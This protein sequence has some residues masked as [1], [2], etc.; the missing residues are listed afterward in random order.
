LLTKVLYVSC[1]L[2]KNTDA[3]AFA[4]GGIVEFVRGNIEG[5]VTDN[6]GC[7]H[8]G[9]TRVYFQVNLLATDGQVRDKRTCPQLELLRVSYVQP[10]RTGNARID[11][12][13]GFMVTG[14]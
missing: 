7:I 4:Y 12:S 9:V 1:K 10:A 11:I 13:D 14:D 5:C 3:K 6:Y 8:R 2:G